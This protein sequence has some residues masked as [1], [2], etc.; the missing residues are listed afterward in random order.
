M[1]L[2]VNAVAY[3][4]LSLAG[5]VAPHLNAVV[6]LLVLPAQL[7]EVAF[8]VCLLIVGVRGGLGTARQPAV[9]GAVA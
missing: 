2:L 5:L 6:S 8:T 7:G 1:W 9:P 4:A 3:L